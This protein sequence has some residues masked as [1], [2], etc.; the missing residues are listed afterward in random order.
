MA[1]LIKRVNAVPS[2]RPALTFVTQD[3]IAFAMPFTACAGKKSHGVAHGI[4]AL[5]FN[6][7]YDGD[8]ATTTSTLARSAVE[9]LSQ[10]GLVYLPS[11]AK[12]PWFKNKKNPEALRNVRIV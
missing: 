9:G 4:P 5:P 2:Y 12:S 6:Q 7:R 1:L 11:R 3:N 8:V 10:S